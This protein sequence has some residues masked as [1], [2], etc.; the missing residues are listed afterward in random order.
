VAEVLGVEIDWRQAAEALAQGMAEVLNLALE[1][2]RLSPREA[3]LAEKLHA[4]KYATAAW[5]ERL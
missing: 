5:N 4:E 2:A 1:E 3:A